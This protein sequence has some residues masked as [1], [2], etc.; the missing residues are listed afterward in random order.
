MRTKKSPF[1]IKSESSYNAYLS[2]SSLEIGIKKTGCI[3]WTDIPELEFD[4]HVIE[5]KFRLDSQGGYSAAGINFRITEED[6]YY[7][8]LVSSKGYF[9]LDVVKTGSPKTLIAWT[10]ISDFNENNINLKI[11]AIDAYF[12]FLVNGNWIG[13]VNDDSIEC[14]CLGFAA[15]SYEETKKE[16]KTGTEKKKSGE[17]VCRAI[18]DY[19]SVDARFKTVD[20]NFRKWTDEMN[21]NAEYRLRL[22]E[23]FA[24]MGEYIKSLN[25]IKKAWKRRD[26]AVRGVAV[27]FEEVRTRKELL[28]AARMSS[29]AGIFDEAE[30]YTDLILEQWVNT[31]EGKLAQ[32]EKIKILYESEKYA[33]LKDFV[34]NHPHKIQKDTEY[35]TMVANS[36]WQLKNYRES[37]ETWAKAFELKGK[38]GVYAVNAANAYEIAD[39][40][41]NALKYFI[42]AAKIFLNQDN[43]PEM[44]A[45]MPKLLFLGG[46]NWE[47]RALAGKWAFSMEDYDKAL[48]EFDTA[49]KLRRIAKPK[50]N[51][52]P[53][54]YY[55]W[56]LVFYI[57]GKKKTAIRLLEKA[58]ALAPDY[59][60]FRKKLEEIS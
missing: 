6:S 18:L 53:A 30:K 51:P 36:Y 47:A 60:L 40:K 10:E 39:N 28:L 1:N 57:K 4:D 5:A 29:S 13:E 24:V 8:A 19:I 9:R 31:P 41:E 11:I 12:I 23:S 32:S 54:V 25:Q 34:L 52:D 7:M 43:V 15:A 45:L 22:A 59:E 17:Y 42:T 2:E 58:V 56:G 38:N 55:L 27:D 48:L 50:P 49:E 33:E 35:Y 37:A 14:G 21:I 44:A 20:E 3:A 16:K 46:Q 26:E